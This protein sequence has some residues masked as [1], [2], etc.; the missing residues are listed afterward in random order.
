MADHQPTM[1]GRERPGLP[2]CGGQGDHR[3]ASEPLKSC[4]DR[5]CL[6]KTKGGSMNQEI[7]R[8]RIKETVSS[9]VLAE[10]DRTAERAQKNAVIVEEMT[11]S[12]TR[13]ETPDTGE[14]LKEPRQE[15]PSFFDQIRQK[16]ESINDSLS[17]IE[18][19]MRRCEL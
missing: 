16:T 17:R 15:Y 13:S 12:I 11:N 8:D 6:N 4:T 10:L 3:W 2:G 1:Q 14:S 7:K 19:I 18:D 9:M 5:D